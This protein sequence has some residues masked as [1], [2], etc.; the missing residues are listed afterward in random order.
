MLPG[1]LLVEV[2]HSLL[3]PALKEGGC[4]CS[5]QAMRVGF[6][7]YGGIEDAEEQPHDEQH[8][9]VGGCRGAD[10]A[11]GR[12]EDQVM[13]VASFK[14]LKWCFLVRNPWNF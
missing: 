3:L 12:A 9:G 13:V 14:V 10:P 6:Q 2:K 8:G 11:V 4:N 5:A 1:Q 7:E